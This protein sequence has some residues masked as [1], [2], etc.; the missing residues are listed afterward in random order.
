MSE[1]VSQTLRHTYKPN[2]VVSLQL[3]DRLVSDLIDVTEDLAKRDSPT[4]ALDILGSHQG[5]SNQNH[6]TL[7]HKSGSGNT[8]D[9]SN[10]GTYAKT[11]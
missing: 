3:I 7:D 11:C 1:A 10:S 5:K 8:K 9:G 4:H 2:C 6:G